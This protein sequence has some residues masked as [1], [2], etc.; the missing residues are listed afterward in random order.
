MSQ[1]KVYRGTPNHSEK[2]LCVSCRNGQYTRNVDGTERT[3]CRAGGYAEP[4]FVTHGIQLCSMYDDKRRPAMWEMEKI[5][6]RVMVNREKQ[7]I[8]FGPTSP[9]VDVLSPADFKEKFPDED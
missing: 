9:R 3:L 2:S 7:Q 6:W 5:A 1:N 8:G 4:I